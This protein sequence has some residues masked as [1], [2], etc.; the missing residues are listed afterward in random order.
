[1]IVQDADGAPS[2]GL[3][4]RRMHVVRPGTVL[5]ASTPVQLY[6]FDVLAVDGRPTI[7]TPYLRRRDLLGGLGLESSL[8]QVP[9][10][11]VGVDA[12]RLLAVADEHHLEG[13]VSK[14]IDS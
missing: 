4:Q 12:D 14:R 3:L 8:V 2:F 7:A 1:L 6:P 13:I 11:W 5:V 10:H 9:L